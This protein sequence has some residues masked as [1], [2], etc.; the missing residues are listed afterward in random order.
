[1]AFSIS[2]H[3]LLKDGT[4]VQFEASP[5]GGGT[6][7]PIYLIMHYTAGTTASGAINHF[8]NPDADASAHIVLDRNGSITQMVAFNR[9][10]WHAG[11]SSWNGM[12]GLNRR[13]I[14]IEIVNAG[15]LRKRADGK[16]VN[17][18]NNVIPDDQ[19][20]IAKHKNESSEA[21]WHVYTQEQIDVVI[22]IGM[23]LR[24]RYDLVDVLGHDDI[25]PS[26][27]VDPGPLF[28]MISVA[29]RIMGRS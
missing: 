17:W 29:S 19:V 2:S 7:T 14:G 15:K 4:A 25:A 28:P 9:I 23:V 16:W 8:K 24:R 20:A 18:A 5:N 10:A 26:R 27:K 21:G 11:L 13:S 6:M 12:S 22:E 3:R 1:M